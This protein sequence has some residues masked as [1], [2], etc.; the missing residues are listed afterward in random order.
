MLL[1]ASVG[2]VVSESCSGVEALQKV[3]TLNR[4]SSSGYGTADLNG[5]EVL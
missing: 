3:E 4:M 1:D 5:V 2:I